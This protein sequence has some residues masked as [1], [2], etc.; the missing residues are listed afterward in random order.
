MKKD[1]FIN[2]LAKTTLLLSIAVAALFTVACNPI[3]PTKLATYEQLYK[4][5]PLTIMVMPPINRSTKVEAKELFYSSLSIP[6]TLKGYYV[7]PPLLTMEI[8]KEESAYDSE[9]FV[10]SS[11]KNMGILFGVDAVL[12]TTIHEW[13]KSTI[14]SQIR[15]KIEYTLKSTKSDK[16]IFNRVGN[17]VYSPSMNSGSILGDMIGAMLTTALTKEITM[18]RKCNI[19]TL[20]DIPEGGYGTKHKADKEE[21]AAPK[22]FSAVLR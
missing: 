10:E 9:M 16:V 6:L 21:S 4:E 5:D 19:Y 15:V 2:I 12:F 22:E 17:I 18:G 1:T 3:M 20:N 7:L 8:L 14:A 13:S 11:L